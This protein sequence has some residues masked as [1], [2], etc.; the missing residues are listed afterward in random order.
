MWAPGTSPTSGC[1]RASRRTS[2]SSPGPSR[3]ELRNPLNTIHLVVHTLRSAEIAGNP[4]K[5]NAQ[6]DAIASAVRRS[7]HFLNNIR[8]LAVASSAQAGAAMVPVATA[9]AT[10]TAELSE[11]AA[12]HEV[13]VRIEGDIPDVDTES[14]LVHLI[15]VNLIGNSIKYSDPDKDQRYVSVSASIIPEE[16]D[17]G[18][19]ELVVE[20][21]GLGVAEELV[22]RLAQS[23]FRASPEVANGT[24]LGLNIVRGLLTDRGGTLEIESEH[25]EG[26][27]VKCRFRCLERRVAAMPSDAF[28]T[29]DVLEISVSRSLERM[30]ESELK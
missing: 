29:D 8:L 3:H 24:G 22:P 25:G 27:K 21:N 4:E 12:E 13:D 30:D 5:L 18:F 28:D 1:G 23:G 15:L 2:R 6:L 10:A 9:I 7:S 14:V 16:H 17:S 11:A 26:T 20:D 19:C